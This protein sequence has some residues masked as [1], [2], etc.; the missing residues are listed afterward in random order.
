[1]TFDDREFSLLRGSDVQR[2]GMYLDLSESRCGAEHAVAEIFN[3]DADRAFSFEIFEPRV[4]E[5]VLLRFEGE[6]ARLP[7]P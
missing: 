1:M 7:P 2:D 5:A 4:P 6:A 3:S